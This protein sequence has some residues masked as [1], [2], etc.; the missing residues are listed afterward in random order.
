MKNNTTE[1]RVPPQALEAEESILSSCLLGYAAIACE[2]LRP[3]DFYRTAH[4]VIFSAITELHAQGQSVDSITAAEHLRAGGSLERVGGKTYLAKLINCIPVASSL[5]HYCGTVK[6]AAIRREVA[7]RAQE[8][9]AAVYDEPNFQT[10]IDRAQRAFTDLEANPG[11][12]CSTSYREL[13]ES[14]PTVWEG[15]GKTTGITGVPSGLAAID[16]LTGGFQNSDLIVIA[17]RPGM[18]KSAFALN[19]AEGAAMAGFPVQVF[20]LEMSKEQLFSRQTAKTARIDSQ[21][22]RVGGI[23]PN[24]WNAIMEAQSRLCQLPVH[25]D[26]TA[27]IHYLELM[28]RTRQTVREHGVKLVVIDYL[29][30]IRGDEKHQRKDLE[31][32]DVT[33]ALKGLAKQLNLPVI[34]LS[35]LNRNV[36]NRDNK[37]P[38]LSDL[39]ESGSIEQDAD[40]VLFLYRDEKYHPK[41]AEPGVAEINFAKHR[42]GPTGVVDLLWTGAFSSFEDRA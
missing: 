39:R 14:M 13:A 20:S 1:C 25:I 12:E 38:I 6:Q 37:R 21:K 7:R 19:I 18:G 40:I 35:Q 31:V 22:F 42:N 16:R 32:G 5:P 34:L 9:L 15:L 30:L 3:A 2:L 26:D 8:V 33:G 24:E 10:C 28:R 27:R 41:T 23:Q 17:A 11:G 4:G 36:E 29:Q